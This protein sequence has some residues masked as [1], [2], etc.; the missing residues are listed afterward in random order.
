MPQ[1]KLQ[2]GDL[3]LIKKHTADS[4]DPTYVGDY[5][6]ISMKGNQV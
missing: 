2:S 5:R 3:V 4:C 1:T 6:I